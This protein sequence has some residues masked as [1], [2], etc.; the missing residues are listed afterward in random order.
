VPYALLLL[1]YRLLF[2]DGAGTGWTLY[3]PLSHSEFHRGRSVDFACFSLHMSGLASAVGAA[4]FFSSVNIIRGKDGKATQI[5]LFPWSIRV[6]RVLLMV[7]LPVLAG[8]ITILIADRHFNT[9]FF[10][11]Y[12]GGD[13]VLYQHLFW[14]FGHP[15]VYVLILPGFGIVS[16]VIVH[17]C[18]KMFIFGKLAMIYS[19]KSI[20]VIGFVV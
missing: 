20:G 12:R 19:I 18:N 4:N 15:E 10:V 5:P 9:S 1:I 11:P 7:S 16:H 8:A 14:F 17:Y 13:P 3:P 2:D 6:T